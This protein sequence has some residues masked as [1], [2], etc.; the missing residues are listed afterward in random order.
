MYNSEV[1]QIYVLTEDSLNQTG[2]LVAI[3]VQ[4]KGET[5]KPQTTITPHTPQVF[6]SICSIIVCSIAV[7]VFLLRVRKFRLNDKLS[8]N[9]LRKVPCRNCRYFKDNRYLNCAVHPSTVLTEQA[10]NCP[11]YCSNK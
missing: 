11:D 9:W 4:A 5:I 3:I 2:L 1:L 8:S 6:A 10:L 7:S